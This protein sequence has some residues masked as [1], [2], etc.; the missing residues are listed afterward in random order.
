[1][2]TTP[3]ID[4]ANVLDSAL[5]SLTL[6]TNLFVGLLREKGTGIPHQAVFCLSAGGAPPDA[7]MYGGSGTEE[8]HSDVK[9]YVRSN[10]HDF[11]GGQT[12]A[13]SVRDAIHHVV[14]SGYLESEVQESEPNYLGQQENGEHLWTITTELLH[15][16]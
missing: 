1:M 11:S 8:R 7:F 14:P 16:Q 6:G 2:P 13:R 3:D 15:R 4:V 5:G 9:I 10:P 12:L